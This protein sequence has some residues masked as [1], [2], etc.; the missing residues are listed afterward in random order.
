MLTAEHTELRVSAHTE[1]SCIS[2]GGE[3]KLHVDT[4]LLSIE[5]TE[6]CRG[7]LYNTSSGMCAAWLLS[8][9]LLH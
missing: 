8:L 9:L 2:R 1:R 5:L 4:L 3:E 6:S 7:M